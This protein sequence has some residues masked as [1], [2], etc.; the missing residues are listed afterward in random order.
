MKKLLMIFFFIPAP[1]ACISGAMADANSIQ[2]YINEYDMAI[3]KAR[4]DFFK[5]IH[6]SAEPAP[7]TAAAI[8]AVSDK[9]VSGAD[10]KLAGDL[11]AKCN[12]LFGAS[13]VAFSKSSGYDSSITA[14]FDQICF[15]NDL[16]GAADKTISEW[17][18]R[19]DQI[20]AA[21]GTRRIGPHGQE[22]VD[23][24]GTRYGCSLFTPF[25]K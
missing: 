12:S 17:I 6:Q 22:K 8:D 16:T 13:N 15:F 4:A 24:T 2:A 18:K 9:N 1:F 19:C 5:A 20:N 14:G 21:L 25:V 11:E 7:G 10:A 3:D 23:G